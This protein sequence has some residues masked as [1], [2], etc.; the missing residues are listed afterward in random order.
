M[1]FVLQINERKREA[2]VLASK[3]ELKKEAAANKEQNKLSGENARMVDEELKIA[4][5]KLNADNELKRKEYETKSKK[6]QAE[7][8]YYTCY[9][10]GLECGFVYNVG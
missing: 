3:Q 8:F 2:Q 6:M 5:E 10:G 7:M 4:T 9:L 1:L